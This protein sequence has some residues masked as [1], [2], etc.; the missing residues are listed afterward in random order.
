ME[1]QKENK[2]IIEKSKKTANQ[3]TSHVRVKF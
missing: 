1:K 3:R 2:E